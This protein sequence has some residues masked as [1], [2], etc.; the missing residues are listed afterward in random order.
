MKRHLLLYLVGRRTSQV[1]SDPELN[2]RW[3]EVCVADYRS[4]PNRRNIALY[5]GSLCRP[6]SLGSTFR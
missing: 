4:R 6:S 1:E 5:L 2:V 3:L